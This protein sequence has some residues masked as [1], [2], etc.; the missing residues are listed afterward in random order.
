MSAS[1]CIGL[2]FGWGPFV[3]ILESEGIAA[4]ACGLDSERPCSAQKVFFSLVYTL[5]SCSLAFGSLP[6]GL[7]LDVA[8]P[9]VASVLAGSLI[10]AG[11]LL[12][13]WLP[14]SGP[15][16]AFI[17]PFVLMGS[18]GTLTALTAF[19]I[20]ACFPAAESILITAINAIF[21]VSAT[22][23]LA[24]YYLYSRFG[25]P[26]AQI[27]TTFAIY[28]GGLFAA[29]AALWHGHYATFLQRPPER[30]TD[31]T[32]T[33]EEMP[34]SS[35]RPPDE[36]FA[37]LDSPGLTLR[38][39]LRSK[40][41][42]VATLWF[43]FHQLRANLYLG[44]AAD[45]LR[46]YGDADGRYMQYLTGM[47]SLALFFIPLISASADRLGVAG[48]M[49]AVTLLAAAHAVSCLV[50]SLRFQLVSFFIFTLLRA[51]TFSVS[52]MLVARIFGFARLGTVYGI[53]QCAGALINLFIP[54]ITAAVLT[55]NGGSWVP[56]F[57]GLLL[58]CAPQLGIV[59]WA[60]RR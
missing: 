24:F 54:L 48:S 53:M 57:W 51:A 19:K 28:V 15:A 22:V 11:N 50:P 17:V 31:L 34:I 16:S 58:V 23:P 36:A 56:V 40:Q 60:T 1:F 38:A 59:S 7:L 21:D 12:L 26:R 29:W 43:V 42:V 9:V 33:S 4:A 44:S 49:Q 47:L 18:G 27:F 2:I 13:A 30:L 39:V 6:A 45:M 37:P 52:A 3:K 5:S 46:S 10:C 41:F 25:R 20:A 55:R 14:A 32:T 35:T 8:G